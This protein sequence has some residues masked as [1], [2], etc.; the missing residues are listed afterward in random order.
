MR[1]LQCAAALAALIICVHARAT[2]FAGT[3]WCGNEKIARSFNDL[4]PRV[5][6]EKCC[7]THHNCEQKILTKEQGYG[8]SNNEPCTI[9]SCSCEAAFFK[10]LHEVNNPQSS[11][12]GFLYFRFTNI[13][14]GPEKPT[15]SCDGQQC[16]TQLDNSQSVRWQFYDLPDY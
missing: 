4:G 7:R 13:C 5:E 14:I 6:I 11:A 15:A 2:T 3:K 16:P 10:C 8:L 9:F 12:L 1:I